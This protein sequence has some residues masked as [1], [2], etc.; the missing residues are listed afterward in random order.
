MQKIYGG[1][2]DAPLTNPDLLNLLQQQQQTLQL[3]QN[4]SKSLYDTSL[5]TQ[6][7]IGG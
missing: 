6:R 1:T 5:A 4:V 2:A 7:K 3:V